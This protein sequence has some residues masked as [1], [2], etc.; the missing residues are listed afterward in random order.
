M[1]LKMVS[2]HVTDPELAYGFYTQV[3]EFE[4]MIEMPEHHVYVV[5]GKGQTTGLLLEPSDHP[6]A[7]A[8]MTG[9]RAE[10]LPALVIGTD[11][12]EA[13]IERLTAAGVTFVGQRFSD[14]SGTAINFDDGVGNLIQLHQAAE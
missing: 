5:A 7:N 14:P 3:L 13:S 11:D 2:L 12:L 10:N 9:L 1:E 6:V 8:Y 4:T